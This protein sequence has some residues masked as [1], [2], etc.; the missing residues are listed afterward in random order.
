MHVEAHAPL[1]AGEGG[2]VAPVVVF[3]LA[4]GLLDTRSTR[5]PFLP[6]QRPRGSEKTETHK[7][8]SSRCLSSPS[9]S[10]CEPLISAPNF[11]SLCVSSL[12]IAY[13]KARSGMTCPWWN[14]RPLGK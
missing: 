3:P 14:C 2:P 5:A 9:S 1:L 8:A 11:F 7:D 6:R 12:R 13:N 4:W 10:V